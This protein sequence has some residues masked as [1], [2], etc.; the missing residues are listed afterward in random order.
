MGASEREGGSDRGRGYLSLGTWSP[1]DDGLQFNPLVEL[2]QDNYDRLARDVVALRKCEASIFFFALRHNKKSWDGLIA[3]LNS[4]RRVEPARRKFAPDL[5]TLQQRFLVCLANVLS[6]ARTYF[7]ATANLLS[8]TF[9]GDPVPAREFKASRAHYYDSMSEYRLCEQV[10]NLLQHTANVPLSV[11]VRAVSETEAS[12]QLVASREELLGCGYGWNARVRSDIQ[13]G[14]DEVDFAEVLDSYWQA[15]VQIERKRIARELAYRV[16]EMRRLIDEFREAG[17]PRD[18][19]AV[20]LTLRQRQDGG[21]NL[22]PNYCFALSDLERLHEMTLAGTIEDTIGVADVVGEGETPRLSSAITPEADA[23]MRAWLLGGPEA[24]GPAIRSSIQSPQSAAN[25]IGGL[26]NLAG[27][28]LS[29]VEHVLGL[30]ALETLE[31]MS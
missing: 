22:D 30:S 31:S 1:T 24:A 29:Q 18:R 11:K 2:D 23:I 7:D 6:A 10:R 8:S 25:A 14:P 12:H 21:M 4:R 16:P 28:A 26:V 5:D 17:L 27:V 19:P 15:I 9:P 20:L 13:S 3:G